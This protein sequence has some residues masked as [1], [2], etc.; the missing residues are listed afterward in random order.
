[1]KEEFSRLTQ[2]VTAPRAAFDS[3]AHR[4]K[5]LLPF[6]L[7]M[8]TVFATSYVVVERIGIGTI[9]ASGVKGHPRAS[10]VVAMVEHRSTLSGLMWNAYAAISTAVTILFV[11]ALL[12][13]VLNT[14]MEAGWRRVFSVVAHAMFRYFLVSGV[15]TVLFVMRRTDFNGFDLNNPVPTNLALFIDG[16][17]TSPFLYHLAASADILSFWLLFLL[18]TGLSA[19]IPRL[20]FRAS[21]LRVA[22]LWGLYVFCKGGVALLQVG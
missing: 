17:T 5:F 6:L 11:A 16:R 1:M 12:A 4:P 19:I 3:V 18:G 10:A 22:T 14:R 8:A 9:A 15:L 21:F 7:C 13:I 20:T 2:V